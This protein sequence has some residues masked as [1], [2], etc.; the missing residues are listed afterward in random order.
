MLL[1]GDD[2]IV[3]DRDCYGSV[4]TSSGSV[5]DSTIPT[6]LYYASLDYVSWNSNGGLPCETT[7]TVD[8][9][10]DLFLGRAPV[11]TPSQAAAFVGKSI[12]Y[13]KSPPESGFAEDM[14]L[15]GMEL[16][17]IINGQSDAYWKTES[18]F[19]SY[20]APYWDYTAYMFYDTATSFPGGASYDLTVSNLKS[21]FNNGYNFAFMATHGNWN[22][23][24]TE[25]GSYFLP[26]DALSLTNSGEQGHIYTIACITNSTAV[27]T[28]A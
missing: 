21:Q 24:A 26:S 20:I 10:Y 12:A 4:L 3:P 19:D 5:T 14:L 15:M 6:D 1:G 27:A 17:S 13:D 23:W 8:L 22:L 28:P 16:W 18:L 7:D 11:R 9:E 2:T 25:S